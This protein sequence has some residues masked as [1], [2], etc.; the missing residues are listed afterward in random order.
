MAF[1]FALR[2]LFVRL[3]DYPVPKT[4]LL[5]KLSSTLLSRQGNS[6]RLN[7][8]VNRTPTCERKAQAKT[9]APL[10]IMP[11]YRSTPVLSFSTKSL[12]NL[13][14]QTNTI[15]SFRDNTCTNLFSYLQLTNA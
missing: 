12:M 14:N 9:E 5:L 2:P 1:I 15:T 13:K 4:I 3:H 7:C 11:R 10:P 6:L 8:H